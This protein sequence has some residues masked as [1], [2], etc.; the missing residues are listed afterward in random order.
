MTS[1]RACRPHELQAAS[2]GGEGVAGSACS[3][4]TVTEVSEDNLFGSEVAHGDR[5]IR[6]SCGESG[7]RQWLAVEVDVEEGPS[8]ETCRFV[9]QL[10][11]RRFINGT[12]SASYSCI[13]WCG[14]GRGRDD[15]GGRRKDTHQTRLPPHMF[16]IPESFVAR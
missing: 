8:I 11:L 12:C 7:L 6:F 4:D 2:P 16:L 9:W 3:F 13:L 15:N 14:C 10:S 1:G 5:G